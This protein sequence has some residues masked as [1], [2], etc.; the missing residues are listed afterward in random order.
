MW[1]RK[2]WKEAAD[3]GRK[4]GRW[5]GSGSVKGWK[6]KREEE[7]RNNFFVKALFI[8]GK[9]QNFEIKVQ[10]TKFLVAGTI[11]NLFLFI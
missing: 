7:I 11:K 5:D 6:K 3:V 2:E 1:R 4:K 9:S 10:Q 8:Q